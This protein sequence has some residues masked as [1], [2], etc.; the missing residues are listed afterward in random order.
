MKKIYRTLLSAAFAALA[1]SSC[2]KGPEA[3]PAAADNTVFFTAESIATRTT[4][5]DPDGNTYP[6]VWTSNDQQVAISLKLDDPKKALV[7][8]SAD[9]KTAAFT[10]SFSESSEAPF[11]F[12]LLS[13]YSAYLSASA[14]EESFGITVPSVQT[15]GPKSVD[16]AAQILVAKSQSF[17]AWPEKVSFALK[18]WTS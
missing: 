8:P 12:Y 7:S 13:P 1:L 2:V 10:A 3:V 18:H 6:T 4:F 14:P 15:P 17:D 5:T 9:G 11:T 16:E